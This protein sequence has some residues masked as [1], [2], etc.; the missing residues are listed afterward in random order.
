M[1]SP[2]QAIIQ[3]GLTLADLDRARPIQP[4]SPRDYS[5]YAELASKALFPR[6]SSPLI[7]KTRDEQEA[8]VRRFFS[9]AFQ[10]EQITVRDAHPYRII[11]AWRITRELLSFVVGRQQ[12]F[13]DMLSVITSNR[14]GC[15]DLW[16]AM[17]RGR[18]EHIPSGLRRFTQYSNAVLS[19][20][21]DPDHPP[22]GLSPPPLAPQFIEEGICSDQYIAEEDYQLQRW[23]RVILLVLSNLG[24]GAEVPQNPALGDLGTRGLHDPAWARILWPMR[25]EIIAFDELIIEETAENIT[26]SSYAKSIRNLRARYGLTQ[27]EASHTARLAMAWLD[28]SLGQTM[29]E[30]RTLVA[31]RLQ[32]IADRSRELQDS[33]TEMQAI[34]AMAGVLGVTRARPKDDV[35]DFID[36]MHQISSE[37]AKELPGTKMIEIE[38]EDDADET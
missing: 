18:V 1:T 32:D 24:I 33:R 19:L 3:S 8:I 10:E 12:A 14:D 35:S 28:S 2:D 7:A 29:E 9:E 5:E 11:V 20:I 17:P 38:A 31:A 15:D 34:R 23:H 30:R 16:Q 4:V 27:E 36:A 25:S 13:S 6:C 21:D 37:R 22:I 26:K